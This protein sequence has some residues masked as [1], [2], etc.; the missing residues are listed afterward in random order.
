MLLQRAVQEGRLLY[1][2]NF[3]LAETHALLLHRL[4]P[5]T[6]APTARAIALRT[7]EQLYDSAERRNTLVRVTSGDEARAFQILA[8]YHDKVFTFTDATSFAVMERLAIPLAL[9]FDGDFTRAGF[10]RYGELG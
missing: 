2:T 7:V 3:V 6:G 4:K 10:V 8:H 1:T 5:A 9:T